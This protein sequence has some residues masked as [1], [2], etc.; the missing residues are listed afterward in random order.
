MRSRSPSPKP[1][2]EPE[3]PQAAGASQTSNARPELRPVPANERR[4]LDAYV[5]QLRS[6]AADDG[7]LP[8]SL[9]P[10]VE[11]VFGL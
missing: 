10:L 9:E 5:A 3:P 11:E 1:E 2:P 8:P 4:E 7:A 6:F